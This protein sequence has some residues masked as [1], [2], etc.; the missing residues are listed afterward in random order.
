MVDSTR[1]RDEPERHK[2]SKLKLAIVASG[3][4]SAQV[5]EMIGK[6]RG[7]LARWTAGSRKCPQVARVALASVLDTTV[8]ELFDDDAR[9]AA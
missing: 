7:Q 8:D 2:P 5:A 4:T 3:L 1:R 6:D 9:V